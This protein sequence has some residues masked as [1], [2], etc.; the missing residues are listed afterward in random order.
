MHF[1]E[2]VATFGSSRL[3]RAMNFGSRN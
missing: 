2:S 3:R 1:I